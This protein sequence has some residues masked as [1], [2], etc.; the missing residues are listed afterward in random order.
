MFSA[1]EGVEQETLAS[2]LEMEID[3]LNTIMQGIIKKYD[4]EM[5]G[6]Q[7]LEYGT[8][9]QMCTRADFYEYIRKLNEPKRQTGLSSAALECLS[10]VALSP[11]GNQKPGGIHTG[12]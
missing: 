5:R 10:V 7:I 4:D 9:Y 11:A 1:G 6:V 8:R 2:C 3:E 12:R